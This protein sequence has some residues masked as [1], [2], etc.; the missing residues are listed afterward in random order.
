VKAI[1]ERLEYRVDVD[2]MHREDAATLELNEIGRVEITTARPVFFDSYRVNTGTG[3]FVLIDPHSNRTVAAGMIRGEVRR[4]VESVQSEPELAEVETPVSPG[5]TWEGWNIPRE[6]RERHNGHPAAVLWLTGLS[7]AGKT[8]I[9]REV[10]RRLFE[11][12]VQTMLLEGDQLRHGLCGDLGFSP[13]D[14]RENIRRVGEVARLFFQQGC[15]VICTFVSPYRSDREALRALFPK[16]RFFEVYVHA[17][18]DV[19]QRRDPKGLYRRHEEGTLVGL[20][21]LDSPYEVPEAPELSLS[22]DRL[23]V[24]ECASAL[25][26]RFRRER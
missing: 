8:T 6:E 14:R 4:V 20:T 1:V 18:L 12:G 13:D 15:V 25:L 3:S 21:G 26:E 9:A 17:P 7:G 10:E 5:V 2:T 24:E 22:T 23:S 19:L 16:G 11:E